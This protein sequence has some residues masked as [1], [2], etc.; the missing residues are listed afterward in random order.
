MS[1]LPVFEGRLLKWNSGNGCGS[2]IEMGLKEFP[3]EGFRVRS[4][5]TGQELTFVYDRAVNEAHEFFDGEGMAFSAT[6]RNI[7]IHLWH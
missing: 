3:H 2:L 7:K 1:T 6:D 4:H 5:H